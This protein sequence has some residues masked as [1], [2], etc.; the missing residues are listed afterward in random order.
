MFDMACAG[1]AKDMDVYPY[2]ASFQIQPEFTCTAAGWP[3][4]T[5]DC[6]WDAPSPRPAL[7]T[8]LRHTRI[9]HNSAW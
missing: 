4:P 9:A 3:L 2:A 6:R 8:K 1:L 7:P 5:A